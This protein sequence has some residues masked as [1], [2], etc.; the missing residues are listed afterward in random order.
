MKLEV[1]RSYGLQ[2]LTLN[3]KG[4]TGAETMSANGPTYYECR[5]C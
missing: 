5:F 2:G 3:L 1:K 4:L